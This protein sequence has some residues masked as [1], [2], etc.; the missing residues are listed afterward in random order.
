MEDETGFR[1]RR[2]AETLSAALLRTGSGGGG[3]E[4]KPETVRRGAVGKF[5]FDLENVSSVAVGLA[6]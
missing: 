6:S 4:V 3:N 5:K 1:L 2:D